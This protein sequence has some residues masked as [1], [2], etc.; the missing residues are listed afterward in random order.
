MADQLALDLHNRDNWSRDAFLIG[1]PNQ[2]AVQI[3]DKWPNW[4]QRTLLIHGPAGCGKTHL[5]HLAAQQS[6]GLI[7]SAGQLND[8]SWRGHAHVVLEDFGDD[9]YSEKALFHLINWVREERGSLLITSRLAPSDWPITLKDLRS[10][11]NA[12]V[13]VEIAQPNDILLTQMLVKD[14][15]NVGIVPSEDVV[16][17]IEKRIPR[18]FSAVRQAVFE[19]N[20]AAYAEKTRVTVPFVKRVM[21]W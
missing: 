2:K 1:G 10:R 4:P 13:A 16:G 20:R 12:I 5:A 6:G 15:A 8:L 11:M 21:R 18:S 3:I 14:F 19:L 17:F 9:A 7:L